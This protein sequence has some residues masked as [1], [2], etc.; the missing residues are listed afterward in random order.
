MLKR[1][2]KRTEVTSTILAHTAPYCLRTSPKTMAERYHKNG[3]DNSTSVPLSFSHFLRCHF[4]QLSRSASLSSLVSRPAH[5]F[6]SL[7]ALADPCLC[8]TAGFP[9]NFTS[10]SG[11][12][13]A[14]ST[15]SPQW[16]WGPVTRPV[17]PTFPST[18]PVSK[19]SPT[20]TSI[21]ER[22]P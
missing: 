2:N 3:F 14:L 8:P 22:C 1:T 5:S 21:S 17:A 19:T 16:R 9:N 7:L 11:F 6:H 20:F 13:R 12:T 18:S 4:S 10:C 15:V